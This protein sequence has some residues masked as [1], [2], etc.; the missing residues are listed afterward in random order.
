[1][2]INNLIV[3]AANQD[4]V[5]CG[6]FDGSKPLFQFNDVFSATGSAYAGICPNQT[7]LKGNVS[8]DPLF[9]N[10]AAGDYHLQAGSRAIDAGT[11]NMAPQ[12]DPDGVIRPQD[13]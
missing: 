6:N 8:T 1:Q 13:G 4:A 2:L 11:L 7:G 10:P 3:A 5:T 12:I 9:R